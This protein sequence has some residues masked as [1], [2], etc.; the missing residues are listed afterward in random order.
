MQDFG[1]TGVV[2][3]SEGCHFER[4]SVGMLNLSGQPVQVR[5]GSKADMLAAIDRVVAD[6]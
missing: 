1:T 6:I 2:A 3:F 5:K 4:L